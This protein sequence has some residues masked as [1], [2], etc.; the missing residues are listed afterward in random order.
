MEIMGARAAMRAGTEI[1]AP[2]FATEASRACADEF[3]PRQR[4][5]KIPAVIT[6]DRT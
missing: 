1:Q 5:L 2:A 6:P 3:V 4:K